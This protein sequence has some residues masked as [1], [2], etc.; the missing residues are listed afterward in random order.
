VL[1]DFKICSFELT[2]LKKS[3]KKK[4]QMTPEELEAMAKQRWDS[5]VYYLLKIN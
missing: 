4:K 2:K 1:T 5:I 3:K